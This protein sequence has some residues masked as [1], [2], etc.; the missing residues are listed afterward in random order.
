[1]DCSDYMS[2]THWNEWTRTFDTEILEWF[3]CKECGFE[4]VK[5]TKYWDVTDKNRPMMREKLRLFNSNS[6]MQ[7][8]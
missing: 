1:M 4:M 7:V 6:N 3:V 5:E 8:K 2:N